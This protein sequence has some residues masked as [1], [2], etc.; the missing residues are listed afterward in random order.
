MLHLRPRSF[1]AEPVPPSN[2]GI[3]LRRKSSSD[4]T[5]PD[6]GRFVRDSGATKNSETGTNPCGTA[7]VQRI[8]MH[9]F[10]QPMIVPIV[11]RHTDDHRRCTRLDFRRTAVSSSIAENRKP[12]IA[13]HR[14]HFFERLSSCFFPW[15]IPRP[16]ARLLISLGPCSLK[17]FHPHR[18]P[19]TRHGFSNPAQFICFRCLRGLR[20]WL[21]HAWI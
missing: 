20:T 6:Y 10:H 16:S 17:T 9:I 5:L 12:S 11:D 13:R 14:E 3:F 7:S 18:A 8:G 1:Q 15:E 2:L 19:D 21:I 4:L